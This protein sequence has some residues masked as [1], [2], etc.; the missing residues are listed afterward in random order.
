VRR[1]HFL[2]YFDTSVSGLANGSPVTLRGLKIGEVSSVGLQY[3]KAADK[4]V[5]PVHFDVEPERIAELNLPTGDLDATMAE[6]IAHGLRARLESASLLTGQKQIAM[7]IYPD[8]PHAVLNKQGNAYVLPVLPGGGEDITAAAATLMGKLNSIPFEKIGD[9]LSATLAGVNG[10][11]NGPDLHQSIASLH[12]TM[13]DADTLVRHLNDASGPLAQK[14]PGMIN[15]LDATA[16]RLNTLVASMQSGYGHESG[17]HND[18]Q[19]LLLQLTDTA[20]SFRVLA[21]LLARH[22]EALIRGR[23]GEGSP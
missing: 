3:D 23:T 1:V 4:V 20:R 6:L 18:V 15:A 9:D 10:M 21:D 22:P 14:L 19:H 7:D 13:A 5:V 17:F 2:A 16:K 12:A 8:A 11:V